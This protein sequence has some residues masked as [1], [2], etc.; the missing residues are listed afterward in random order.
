MSGD[1]DH[2]SDRER[3]DEAL[4][5]AAQAQAHAGELLQRIH[6]L[7]ASMGYRPEDLRPGRS[8]RLRVHRFGALP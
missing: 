7:L 8:P 5:Q 2:E 3:I 6:A 1:T 4:D